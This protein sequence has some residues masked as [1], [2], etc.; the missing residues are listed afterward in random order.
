MAES[1]LNVL[2]PGSS[3]GVFRASSN[4]VELRLRLDADAAWC[5]VKR[6]GNPAD[7]VDIAER[8]VEST[9]ERFHAINGDP[10]KFDDF[11]KDICP[12]ARKEA[13]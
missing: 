3:G 7:Y 2:P 12:V 9:I 6:P 1:N 8:D 5:V 11:V 4:G 10:N 13:A